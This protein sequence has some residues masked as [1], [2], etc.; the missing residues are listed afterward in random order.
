MR[1]MIL[2]ARKERAEDAGSVCDCHSCVC[3]STM[4]EKTAPPGCLA[5]HTADTITLDVQL[6]CRA[7]LNLA[8]PLAVYIIAT[9]VTTAARCNSVSIRNLWIF[10][11]S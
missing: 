9:G 8:I 4:T 2:C 5:Q 6:D 7:A 10:F 1:G 3:F 11:H